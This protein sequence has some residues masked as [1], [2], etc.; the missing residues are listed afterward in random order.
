MSKT[1]FL[2]LVFFSIFQCLMVCLAITNL[3]ITID[4]AA[5]L[6]LKSHITFDLLNLLTK[7]WSSSTSVCNWIRVKCSSC[8]QRVTTLI[9][10]DMDLTGIIPRHLGNLSFLI[11]LENSNNSFSGNLPP[12]LSHLR[13]LKYLN[14]NSNNFVGEI[15][16]WFSF[17]PQLQDLSLANNRFVNQ[18][19]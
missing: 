1:S 3:N 13:R 4:Q 2:F 17:L 15:S 10:I 5:L 11:Y 14:A 12:E 7:N 19:T 16:L 9:I 18:L 6:A 8:H